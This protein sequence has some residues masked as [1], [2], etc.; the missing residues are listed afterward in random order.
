MEI[1]IPFPVLQKSFAIIKVHSRQEPAAQWK[2]LG[3]ATLGCGL[4]SCYNSKKK[5]TNTKSHCMIFCFSS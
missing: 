5:L 2:V 4:K 3:I 1:L